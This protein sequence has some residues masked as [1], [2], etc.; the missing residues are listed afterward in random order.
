MI[1]ELDSRIAQW[2]MRSG[3][4]LCAVAR[5]PPTQQYDANYNEPQKENIQPKTYERTSERTAQ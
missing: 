5:R 1:L 3:D 4:R 2:V